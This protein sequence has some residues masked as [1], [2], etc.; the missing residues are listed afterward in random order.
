MDIFSFSPMMENHMENTMEHK[1]KT[2]STGS[3]TVGAY[4]DD[5]SYCQYC[6]GFRACTS[7]VLPLSF[8]ILEGSQGP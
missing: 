6:Q 8:A 1:T 4:K 3:C 2:V 5:L 7:R